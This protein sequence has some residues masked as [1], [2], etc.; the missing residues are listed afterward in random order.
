MDMEMQHI[1]SLMNLWLEQPG[2]NCDT[3]VFMIV[4]FLSATSINACG[5]DLQKFLN[6]AKKIS[7][8]VLHLEP[9][10]EALH[11]SHAAFVLALDVLIGMSQ[12]STIQ[13]SQ[14]MR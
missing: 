8:N 12:E 7:V 6:N 13:P 9:R 1:D 5:F 3:Y 2:G 4:K 14:N 11:T 10:D